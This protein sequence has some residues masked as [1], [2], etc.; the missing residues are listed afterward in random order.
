L[1][2][3]ILASRAYYEFRNLL[4]TLEHYFGTFIYYIEMFLPDSKYGPPYCYI[5]KKNFIQIVIDPW[6]EAQ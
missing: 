5:C 1:L 4:F 3:R 2:E 6:E